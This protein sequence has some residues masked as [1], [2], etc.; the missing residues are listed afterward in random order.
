M[1]EKRLYVT[2]KLGLE[3]IESEFPF[4]IVEA[5]YHG[6]K[7]ELGNVKRGG[8]FVCSVIFSYLSHERIIGYIKRNTSAITNNRGC[9]TKC[10]SLPNIKF[11]KFCHILHPKK[12]CRTA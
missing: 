3:I 8:N 5:E 4:P 10:F 9:Y 2:R 11:G 7:V 12:K 6:K 1:N